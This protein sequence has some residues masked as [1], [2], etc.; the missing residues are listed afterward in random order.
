MVCREGVS[1]LPI[2]LLYAPLESRFLAR[3][4]DLTLLHKKGTL[5]R[6]VRQ[7]HLGLAGRHQK[8][9]GFVTLELYSLRV[10]NV[11]TFTGADETRIKLESRGRG[12]GGR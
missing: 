10:N 1:Y 5:G 9:L 3:T 7:L 8:N 11:T 12:G 2:V 6:T 4:L